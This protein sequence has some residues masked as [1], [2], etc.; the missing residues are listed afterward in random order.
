MKPYLTKPPFGP[1]S[2]SAF[3]NLARVENGTITWPGNLDIAP[4]TLYEKS[5]PCPSI[6]TQL[7]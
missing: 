2:D 5:I 7:P 4:E 6:A 3:F 1:L